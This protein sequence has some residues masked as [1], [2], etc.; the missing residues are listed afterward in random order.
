[1]LKRK[2]KR[3]FNGCDFEHFNGILNIYIIKYNIFYNYI[4]LKD[5][6]LLY[7]MNLK[8]VSYTTMS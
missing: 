2:K 4:T 7:N 6:F 8:C 3:S 1:M 5:I